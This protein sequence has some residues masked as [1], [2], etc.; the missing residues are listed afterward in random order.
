MAVGAVRDRSRIRFYRFRAAQ[1][2][3]RCLFI[4]TT[5]AMPS[6]QV[7]QMEKEPAALS[8]T[9][10]AAGVCNATSFTSPKIIG[11]ASPAACKLHTT[12]VQELRARDFSTDADNSALIVNNEISAASDR[13][14][15]K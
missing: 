2:Y 8:H 6:P 13:R 7:T 3:L 4:R 1:V 10:R 15:I 12:L 9:P 11:L 14:R 5:K